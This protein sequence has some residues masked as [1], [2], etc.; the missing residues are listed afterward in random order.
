MAIVEAQPHHANHW[1]FVRRLTLLRK[2]CYAISKDFQVIV[3]KPQLPELKVLKPAKL[4][5]DFEKKHTS[6]KINLKINKYSNHRH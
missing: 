4:I 3:R 1:L 2:R 6:N 5:E